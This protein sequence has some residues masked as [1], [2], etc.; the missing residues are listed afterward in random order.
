[1]SSGTYNPSTK[2]LNIASNILGK[3]MN[4]NFTASDISVAL[5]TRNVR[6]KKGLLVKGDKIYVK[7]D[8]LES[9]GEDIIILK[10]NVQINFYPDQFNNI[11]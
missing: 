6:I 5:D 7:S 9:E 3:Y 8:S 11:R 2:K 10:G 4:N 1:A